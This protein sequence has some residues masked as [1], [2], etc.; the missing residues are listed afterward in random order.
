MIPRLGSITIHQVPPEGWLLER[1]AACDAEYP[2]VL[3]RFLTG[4]P[5]RRQCMALLMARLDP[6]NPCDL[7]DRLR[8]LIEDTDWP[9]RSPTEII[10][11]VMLHRRVRDIMRTLYPDAL[12][13]V[14]TLAKLSD[15]LSVHE[16]GTL[17]ALHTEPQHRPR[18][19]ALR[20]LPDIQRYAIPIILALPAPYISLPVLRRLTSLEQAED[21]ARGIEL[22][23]RINPGVTDDALRI[24]L[25]ASLPSTTIRHW[26]KR[27]L[28]RATEF[29]MAVPSVNSSEMIVLRSAAAMRD[30]ARRF[31]NCL[32]CKI[33]E[34]ALGR[35]IYIEGR[36]PACLIELE[37]LSDGWVFRSIHGEK[38]SSVDPATTR[39][40]LK[41]LH[42]CGVQIP[43]RHWQAAR[44]NR[45]ARLARIL[46]PFRD[47]ADLIDNELI[48]LGQGIPNAA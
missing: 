11:H 25:E 22:I 16:Y 40:V 41:K 34:C 18:I 27:W 8:P 21:L 3:R 46:D 12:G 10:S 38:N 23:K 2:A 43:S 32:E 47:Q 15:P 1:L 42:G 24:S 19:A 7:A 33:E 35:A 30:A 17:T 26:T 37:C 13:L 6:Q 29:W 39:T 20:H 31:Q 4:S 14:R 48:D 44:F 36:S 9:N 28:E 45:V 5:L